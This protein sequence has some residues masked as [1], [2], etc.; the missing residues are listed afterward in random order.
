MSVPVT[1]RVL[2]IRLLAGAL[3]DL[4][5]LPETSTGA[6]LRKQ[7]IRGEAPTHWQPCEPC[8]GDG[9]DRFRRPCAACQGRGR[10]K[11]DP[12]TGRVISGEQAPAPPRQDRWL[13]NV[14]HGRGVEP[15]R[16]SERCRACHGDGHR[17]HPPLTAV[18]PVDLTRGDPDT[19]LEAAIIRRDQAGSF[20]ELETCLAV[21]RRQ[22][23]NRHRV[24]WQVAVLRS[25]TL[26]DLDETEHRWLAEADRD[27]ERMMPAVIRVPAYLHAAGKQLRRQLRVVRGNGMDGRALGWRNSEIRRRFTSGEL[28]LPELVRETGL[29]RS[30]LYEILYGEP[31]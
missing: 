16:P 29:S 30:R 1:D 11:I 10:V 14:C 2:A 24:F 15:K 23:P 21:L 22:N 12:Y 5:H 6:M 7:T 18:Q 31:A 25:R 3:H 13:C 26:A 4:L 19:V 28:T 27:L 8:H 20:H 9:Q 17:E